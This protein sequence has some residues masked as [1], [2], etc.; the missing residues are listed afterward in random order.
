MFT[1]MLPCLTSE[2]ADRIQSEESLQFAFS[3]IRDA[4]EDFSEKNRLGQGG[5]GAV[6]KVVNDIL[7]VLHIVNSHCLR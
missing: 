6:Y 4:T 7:L 3:T 2:A 5:F 1:C